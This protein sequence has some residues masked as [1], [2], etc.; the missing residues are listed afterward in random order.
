MM[1]VVSGEQTHLR[2]TIIQFSMPP[3][4]HHIR[5]IHDPPESPLHPRLRTNSLE[6]QNFRSPLAQHSSPITI[7]YYKSM[8][9]HWNLSSYI[10]HK[11]LA[12]EW[13]GDSVSGHWQLTVLDHHITAPF[14]PDSNISFSQ[15]DT[16]TSLTSPGSKGNRFAGGKLPSLV[17]RYCTLSSIANPRCTAVAPSS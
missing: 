1:L 12:A 10:R 16:I 14:T 5:H 17:E 2:A 9:S 8:I 7:Q 4:R 15:L 13:H 11:V 6:S 3:Q